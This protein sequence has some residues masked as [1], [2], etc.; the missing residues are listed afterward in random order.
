MR[1][2]DREY[3]AVEPL[4]PEDSPILHTCA[5]GHCW[6]EQPDGTVSPSWGYGGTHA[7]FPDHDPKRCPEPDRDEEGRYECPG[8]RGRFFCGHGEPGVMC[9]PW[10]YEE[11]CKPPPPA[12]GKPAVSSARWMRVKKMLPVQGAEGGPCTYKPGWTRSWVPLDE[13]GSPAAEHVR[14]PTLF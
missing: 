5:E 9:D 10:N 3:L 13:S 1:L 11:G 4:P 2:P 12:C 6:T 7:S 8:C 14:E